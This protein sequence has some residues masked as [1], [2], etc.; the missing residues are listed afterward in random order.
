MKSQLNYKRAVSNHQ[1]KARE[2]IAP[3][4]RCDRPGRATP[5]QAPLS[6]V[7]SAGAPRANHRVGK[8]KALAPTKIYFSI[9][10]CKGQLAFSPYHT[11]RDCSSKLRLV[12]S[13]TSAISKPTLSK[14]APTK[15]QPAPKKQ[16]TVQPARFGFFEMDDEDFQVPPRPQS[17]L[18]SPKKVYVAPPTTLVES[19]PSA[20]P[21]VEVIRPIKV[22]GKTKRPRKRSSNPRQQASTPKVH[23]LSQPAV[24]TNAKVLVEHYATP[25]IKVSLPNVEIK[26]E[27]VSAPVSIAIPDST[28]SSPHQS[29]DFGQVR[30]DDEEPIA[31]RL[32]TL[33]SVVMFYTLVAVV[34]YLW[35]LSLTSGGPLARP[36]RVSVP[37]YSNSTDQFVDI[38]LTDYTDLDLLH[39]ITWFVT[40]I[41]LLCYLGLVSWRRLGSGSTIQCPPVK[42][43][44]MGVP[45]NCDDR[46]VD[47]PVTVVRPQVIK[48]KTIKV[49]PFEG[50][51][52]WSS[53]SVSWLD[54]FKF[55]TLRIFS[56]LCGL[57]GLFCSFASMEVPALLVVSGL[58]FILTYKTWR[59]TM[60]GN[61]YSLEV[62]LTRQAKRW[63]VDRQVFTWACEVLSNT[64]TTSMTLRQFSNSVYNYCRSQ[65]EMDDETAVCQSTRAYVAVLEH[66]P[67]AY[68]K[69]RA[70]IDSLVAIK[71][72]DD[73]I[74]EGKLPSGDVLPA[75]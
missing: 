32:P 37:T 9:W 22:E 48:D 21:K 30:E 53:I 73:Y 17:K 46:G 25:L 68:F 57:T 10:S 15:Q 71:E 41:V 6:A 49:D 34:C 3:G 16:E 75:D 56:A 11:C 19:A 44:C 33:T 74:N 61:W 50:P 51:I 31:R 26:V 52:S 59:Y 54:S 27:S 5:Y 38:V 29:F 55:H 60:W 20:Q 47:L 12:Q 7:A 23:D 24:D 69:C 13:K 14:S 28:E 67:I 4:G 40:S 62:Q 70:A 72:Q 43:S 63:K 64:R 65:L 8:D 42:S 66:N 39:D 45:S 35:Y 36:L 18:P 2:P 58:L 1:R